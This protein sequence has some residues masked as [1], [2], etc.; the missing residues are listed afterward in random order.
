M[1]SDRVIAAFGVTSAG[2]RTGVL[3]T[4]TGAI[5]PWKFCPTTTVAIAP[6]ASVVKF[7]GSGFTSASPKRF[8]RAA[9]AAFARRCAAS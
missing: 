5:V 4:G 7:G 6:F 8:A 1:S 2:C 9:A 3:S